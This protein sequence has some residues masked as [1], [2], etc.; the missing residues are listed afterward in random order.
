LLREAWATSFQRAEISVSVLRSLLASRK[1]P[2]RVIQ[3]ATS[4]GESQMDSESARESF[5]ALQWTYCQARAGS[6]SVPFPTGA[7]GFSPSQNFQNDLR[8]S[9][10]RTS[11]RF[12]E[13]RGF[14]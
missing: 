9:K 8:N 12:F 4:C 7:Q 5:C 10:G 3:A 2:S 6:I 1:K 13:G 14:V 11:F